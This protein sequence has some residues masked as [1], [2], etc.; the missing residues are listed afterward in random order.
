[1]SKNVLKG[2]CPICKYIFEDCQCYFAGNA[3]PD[4]SVRAKVVFDHLYLFDRAQIRHIRKVQH[5]WRTSYSDVFLK[6]AYKELL[7]E[8]L[9]K[10]EEAAD[11]RE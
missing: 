7:N 6:K 10:N 3:H 9:G 5:H 1:M 4:R 11:G 2:K 8:I